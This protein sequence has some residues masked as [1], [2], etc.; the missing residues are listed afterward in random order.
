MQSII[1]EVVTG[2]QILLNSI[3]VSAQSFVNFFLIVLMILVYSMFIW[4]F[5]KFISAKNILKLNLSQYNKA[6]FPLFEKILATGFYLLEYIIIL[7]FIIFFWFSAFTMFL[8]LMTE[9]LS[10]SALLLISA[11]TIGAIRMSAYYKEE[12]A[13]EL[14]K[15]IPFT[16]LAFSL[17]NPTFFSVERIIGQFNE[18]PSFFSQIAGYLLFI[19][20]L[21]TILRFFDF[22][23]SLLGVDEEIEGG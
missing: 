18:I 20:V 3:P 10:T 1:N 19:I 6:T 4:K 12:L 16:L 5:Y 21:E 15:L 23:F 13:K 11:T 8:I 22:V 7:P 2:Y 14:A 17:L 9:N